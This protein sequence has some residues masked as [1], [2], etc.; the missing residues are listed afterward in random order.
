MLHLTARQ[1]IP[2]YQQIYEQLRQGILDGALP[3]GSCLTSTRRLAAELQVGR[4]TVEN[5]YAQLAIEGYVTPVPGSGFVINK[6]QYDIHPHAPDTRQQTTPLLTPADTPGECRYDFHY[7]N[8]EAALFPYRAWRRVS[9][10]VFADPDARDANPD[11]MHAYED[12]KGSPALRREIMRYLY[13]S[14]GVRC[15]TEQVVICSGI[16]GGLSLLTRMIYPEHQRVAMEEPGYAGARVVFQRAGIQICPIPVQEDGMDTVA[17]AASPARVAHLAPSHQFPT[18]AIM[19]IRKRKEILHWAEDC[20]GLIIEDD[21]NSEFR[22]NGKPIPSLQSIDPHGRTIYMGTFSKALSPGLR[23]GYMVLPHRLLT[24]FDVAHAGFQC[25][26]PLFDQMILAR[27]MAEGHWERHIRRMCQINK[28]KHDTLMQAIAARFGN[29]VRVHGCNAGV[30]VLLE[31]TRGEKEVDLI[32]QAAEHGVKV[33]PA[34]SG[35]LDRR[36]YAGNCLLLGYGMVPEC[37]IADAVELLHRAWFV[38]GGGSVA[39]RS[40]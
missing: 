34:S 11:A 7:G 29:R 9:A 18:G 23:V 40:E 38:Q 24:A 8:M 30:H 17:L 19:P 27:F 36:G 15:T 13:K 2:L 22:Y 3:E 5:A 14:R 32:R 37:D 4:N 28:K 26:V 20:D 16:Q 31:F 12:V 10:T 21:F 1:G 39:P 35:W 33:Y 25:T 6:V